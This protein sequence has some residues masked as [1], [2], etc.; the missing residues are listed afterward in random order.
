[1]RGS[2]L[3]PIRII[4]RRWQVLNAAI[5]TEWARDYSDS[6]WWYNERASLSFFAGAVWRSG[7]WA[8]EEY[9]STK[10][11]PAIAKDLKTRTGRYDINFAIGSHEYIAEAKQC[12]P[13]LSNMRTAHATMTNSIRSATFDSREAISWGLPVLS[14][15]FAA[16]RIIASHVRQVPALLAQFLSLP[17][18]AG[19]IAWSFP[20]AA[21]SLQPPKSRY[22][23]PGMLVHV[24]QV[25]KSA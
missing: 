24:R 7:G 18:P 10:K 6:P 20:A 8:L 25:R 15:V 12:W 4:L 17:F 14:I 5:G 19:I 1:M 21:R 23:F 2:G 22:I 13:L 3:A 16:P 9:S 11:A